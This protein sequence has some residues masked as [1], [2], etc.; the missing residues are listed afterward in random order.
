MSNKLNQT[1]G[2]GITSLSEVLLATSSKHLGVTT[3]LMEK[4]QPYNTD[5]LG[6]GGC[7]F[8]LHLQQEAMGAKN[9][10]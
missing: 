10:L 2:T 8:P 1:N 7:G 4:P 5:E 9:D 3:R 6:V